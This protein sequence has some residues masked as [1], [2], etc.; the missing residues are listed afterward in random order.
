MSEHADMAP[1]TQWERAG[2]GWWRWLRG[3][4]L[5]VNE[6][7][8]TAEVDARHLSSSAPVMW[9]A[10][11]D[12]EDAQTWCEGWALRVAALYLR[13]EAGGV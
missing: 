10:D 6:R 3:V 11:L 1:T 5:T 8:R 13:G 9:C 2:F 12:I 7:T 4:K